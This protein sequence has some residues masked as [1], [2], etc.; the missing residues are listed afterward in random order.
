MERETRG[1]DQRNPQ[2]AQNTFLSISRVRLY[3]RGDPSSQGHRE[4]GKPGT[5]HQPTVGSLLDG[6]RPL[7]PGA[8]A[9]H[10]QEGRGAG[11]R[12]EN[13]RRIVSSEAKQELEASRQRCSSE[14]CRI[15]WAS[16]GRAPW[17]TGLLV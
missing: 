8:E 12:T 1:P 5:K 17:G 2:R 13:L 7:P 4:K 3:H 9:Q 11:W 14:S 10:P 15:S 6:L 16:P